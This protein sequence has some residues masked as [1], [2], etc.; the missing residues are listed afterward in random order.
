MTKLY[1]EDLTSKDMRDFFSTIRF[2]ENGNLISTKYLKSVKTIMRATIDRAIQEGYIIADPLWNFKLPMGTI[3]N[4]TER[5]ISKDDLKILFEVIKKNE[6]FKIMIPILLL[7][8]LRIG[9]F[10]ALKWSNIDYENK[11]IYIKGSAKKQYIEKNGKIKSIGTVI[12]TTKSSSSVRELPVSEQVLQLLEMWKEYLNKKPSVIKKQK[13]NH[14]DDIVFVNNNER[15][16]DYGSIYK[17]LMDFLKKNQLQHCGVLFHKL[18][19][20]YATNLFDAGVDIDVISKLLGHANIVTT[21][22]FYVKVNIEPKIAAIQK[23]DEYN[24]KNMDFINIT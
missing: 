8:G 2:K 12:G 19:H 11:I 10:L 21:A 14:L 16:F 22:S 15:L 3:P 5:L 23:M 17:A 1:V 9:E 7:T 13:E 24:A 18:R 6:R 4:S 20:C